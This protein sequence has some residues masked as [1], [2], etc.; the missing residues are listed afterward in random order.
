MKQFRPDMAFFRDS[1]RQIHR[2][3]ELSGQ[4]ADTA[5]LVSAFL[6]SLGGFTVHTGIG[7]HG[8]AAV[9]SNGDGPCLLLRADMD[10]L[11]ILEQT[12]LPYASQ[13]T[14]MDQDAA[15]PVMH[16]CG[17]DTHVAC[18][19]ATTQL[20][21]D[22]RAHWRGTLICL[23][24]PAEETLSGAKAMIEDGLFEKVPKPDLVLAQHV[25]NL[26]TGAITSRGGPLLMACESLGVRIFGAGGHGG[27]PHQCVDPVTIGCSI[28]TKLQTIVSREVE[29]GKLGILTCGSIHAGDTAGTIPDHLDLKVSIRAEDDATHRKMHASVKRIIEAECRAGGATRTPQYNTIMSGSATVN[30]EDSFQRLRSS[31][32][33]YFGSDYSDMDTAAA[34]E[35]VHLLATAAGAPLVMWFF[36]GTDAT[37]WDETERDGRLDELP[38]PHSPFFA[39]S[40]ECLDVGVNALSL[41]AL[42][43][44]APGLHE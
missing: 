14:M 42:T 15:K 13:R 36:G 39:P 20:L 37:Q 16:A 8:I 38:V 7:G 34:T 4:E 1:Y 5:L 24:Q 18:L 29:P 6:E 2:M 30:D 27:L 25:D 22:S 31:F 23:F 12:G 26:R 35:D 28:V 43:F 33:S 40:I 17:H 41:A 3:P 11:A 21:Y 32:V 10:A 19:M 44:F 9:L